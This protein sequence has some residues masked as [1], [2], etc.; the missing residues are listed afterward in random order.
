MLC[1]CVRHTYT[2]IYLIREMVL[3]MGVENWVCNGSSRFC[4]CV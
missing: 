1:A 3:Y 2:F 4:V